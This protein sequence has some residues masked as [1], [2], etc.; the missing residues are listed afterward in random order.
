MLSPADLRG[1]LPHEWELLI[2]ADTGTYM[3]AI[4]IA[5]RPRPYAAFV[6]QEF[7][8]YRYVANEPELLGLTLA[9]WA[10]QVTD[11]AVKMR[12]RGNVDADGNPRV[13]AWADP[14]TQFRTE[15]QHYGLFLLPNNRKLELRVEIAREYQQAKPPNQL[16]YLAP[17]LKVLPYELEYAKWPED[18][19]TAGKYERIKQHDH[20]LDCYEHVVSRRPRTRTPLT[21]R[22]E[23][24]LER[25]RREHGLQRRDS[26]AD[27]HTGRL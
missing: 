26:I 3:S 6:L 12:R 8:N 11:F 4:A 5:F 7:P 23:T 15:L 17:W 9:Q 22:K 20:T 10:Q 2:G 14:N 1:P 21:K 18:H 13:K 16:L 27:P 19:T 24:F 25:F